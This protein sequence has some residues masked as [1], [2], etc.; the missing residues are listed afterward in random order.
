MAAVD[1]VA[2]E[3]SRPALRVRRPDRTAIGVARDGVPQS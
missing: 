2:D 1:H 3:H